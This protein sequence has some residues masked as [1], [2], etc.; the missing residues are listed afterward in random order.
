MRLEVFWVPRRCRG[1]ELFQLGERLRE[2]L[3]I[4]ARCVLQTLSQVLLV[5]LDVTEQPD[6]QRNW[7]VGLCAENEQVMSCG[8]VCSNFF[9]WL[10]NVHSWSLF[11]IG[12]VSKTL[13]FQALGCDLKSPQ[14]FVNNGW[15]VCPEYYC[16]QR[17]LKKSFF[18]QNTDGH[19]SWWREGWVESSLSC[20]VL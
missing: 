1:A 5:G 6:R 11:K 17:C 19:N 3:W 7:A 16:N 4:P 18:R 2:G 12:S 10:L 9:V 20:E 15:I 8:R 13:L 14:I